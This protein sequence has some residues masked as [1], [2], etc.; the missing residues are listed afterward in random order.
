MIRMSYCARSVLTAAVSI[1]CLCSS[2]QSQSSMAVENLAYYFDLLVS[3]NLE[4]AQGLW[5]APVVER[6]GRF[7]ITYTGMPLKVDCTS[8]IVRN[9]DVMRDYVYQAAKSVTELP[10]GEYYTLEYSSVVQG[11]KIT[12][13]Y[14]MY[15]DG[16]Y[17]WL[18]HP[19]EY[20]GRHWPIIESRYFRIH[21]HPDVKGYLHGLVLAEADRFIEAMADSLSLSSE[22]LR[23]IGQNKI[24]YFYCDSDSTVEAI[25]GHK[26]KGTLDLATNDVISAF[27][28]HYHEIFHLLINIR[29][30]EL[31]LYTQP[32]LREG[33]AVCYGGRWGK[34]PPTLHYLGAF[35]HEQKIVEVDS[36]L[37]MGRFQQQAVADMAYPV[38]GLFVRFLIENMGLSKF[39]DL[40]VD[41]SGA[42]GYLVNMKAPTLKKILFEALGEPSWEDLMANFAEYLQTYHDGRAV[43]SPGGLSDG[44]DVAQTEQLAIRENQDWLGVTYTTN[45][46]EPPTGNLLFSKDDNLAGQRSILFEE[47]YQGAMEFE[48]Y[49]YGLRFD[50]NEAGLYDYV[51]NQLL[52]KYI[53][54]ITPSDDY[55]NEAGT[56]IAVRFRK[57]LCDVIS[58]G[59]GEY[60]LLA[61]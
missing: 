23:K 25:T 53:W 44:R 50:V 40:Y 9:I 5:T 14:Y 39:L 45:G 20:Y 21:Y 58:L 34:A 35:L 12:H 22:Q 43:F 31:P 55:K 1:V 54:G 4:S 46:S 19:Q 42:Y 6:S 29:L 38:A 33:I 17:F 15:F 48:G 59:E 52:A 16:S 49:R 37:T 27:F 18:T 60:K 36:I 57:E 30:T 13:L 8:P 24:E 56:S 28:P 32:I 2:I 51:T 3:G 47:Q 10:G 61:Y 26:I 7:G 11:E 41:L